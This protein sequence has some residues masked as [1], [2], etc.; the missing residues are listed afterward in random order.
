MR[1]KVSIVSRNQLFLPGMMLIF[2]HNLLKYSDSVE[3]VLRVLRYFSCG[4]RD[5][6]LGQLLI[7]V[8]PLFVLRPM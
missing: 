8:L 1:Y 6:H 7:R 3:P 4:S 5:H 2:I